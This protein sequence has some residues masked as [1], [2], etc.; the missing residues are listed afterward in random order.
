MQ[1][2]VI[3]S[4]SLLHSF[5][6]Q[7]GGYRLNELVGEHFEVVLHRTVLNEMLSVLGRVY[8]RWRERGLVSDEM[9][10]IRR[11]HASWTAT[12]CCNASLDADKDLLEAEDLNDLDVGEID[13]IALAKYTADERFSYVLFLTDDYDAGECAKQVFDKYQIGTVV[14]SADLI[15]F[16]GIRFKLAKPEI[17]Q[18]LRNLIA[19]YTSLY[20]SLLKEVTILL[21]GSESS[22][23]FPLVHRGDFARATEA[24][25]RL[26][27]NMATRKKLSTLIEEVAALA[28]DKSV[29]GHALLRLRALDGIHV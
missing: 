13:C 11:S 23:V 24:V 15:S 18:G 16:F 4:C 8:P 5:H 1:P 25:S 10:E 17:H 2:C 27:L 22:Y 28:A 14:R 9:S 21:P 6:V 20:E 12:R 29:L 26:S 3:D 19:F 7:V